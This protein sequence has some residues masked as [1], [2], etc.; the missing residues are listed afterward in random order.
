MQHERQA[1]MST[2][3]SESGFWEAVKRAGR[4]AGRAVLEP[5]FTLYYAL[6]DRDT[7]VWAQGTIVG[8]LAYFISPL[9]A[10]P[11]VLP[12]LGY[13]DD[14]AVL[15]GAV[16]A[17]TAHIKPEHKAKARSQVDVILGKD[18]AA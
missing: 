15:A 7:P 4:K 10:I 18:E 5:A 12:V 16:M 17:V 14:A 13:T 9:D 8:A 2:T 6:C 3:Y 11:D 1:V